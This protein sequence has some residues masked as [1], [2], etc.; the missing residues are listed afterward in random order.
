MASEDI[1]LLIVRWLHLISAAFWVGGSLFYLFVIRT[2]IQKHPEKPS[3]FLAAISTEFRS[4]VNLCVFL[5]LIT[6]VILALNRLTDSVTSMSYVIT[7]SVKSTL[8][9]WM[10]LSFQSLK[11]ESVFLE[12]YSDNKLAIP[13]PKN[14]WRFFFSYTTLAVLGL[15]VLFLSDLLN[16][17]FQVALRTHQY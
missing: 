14:I 1:F 5:L 3:R 15:I 11:R 8:S 9:I 7:L 16:I 4:T 17:I 10:F 13:S 12:M 6:G 2:T